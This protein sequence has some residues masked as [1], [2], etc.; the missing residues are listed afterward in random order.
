MKKRE[1]VGI[2][3]EKQWQMLKRNSKKE[4]EQQRSRN[5]CAPCLRMDFFLSSHGLLHVFSLLFPPVNATSYLHAPDAIK[6]CAGTDDETR[7]F[8]PLAELEAD[9]D[10]SPALCGCVITALKLRQEKP[11]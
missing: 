6:D 9:F 10:S 8:K 2:G 3:K 5:V 7:L 1:A 11:T 4:R